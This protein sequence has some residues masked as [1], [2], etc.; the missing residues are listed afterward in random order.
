[1]VDINLL[2]AGIT[3]LFINLSNQTRFVVSVRNTLTVEVRKIY[4]R[5]SFMQGIKRTVSWVGNKASDLSISR[6]E[7]HLTPKDGYLQSQTMILNGVPLELTEDGSIPQLN[8]V[9]V[10]VNSPILIAPLS[11][12]FIVFPNFEAPTCK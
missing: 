1:M 5:S 12:A 3:A 6:E 8:P 9:L 4:K 10:D 7:Y 11:I 2:Q